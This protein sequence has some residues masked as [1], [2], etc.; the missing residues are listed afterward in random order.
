MKE[1]I[2]SELK[3]GAYWIGHFVTLLAT[4]VGVYYAAIAGFD[5]A[6]RLEMVKADRGTY[7]VADSL[8]KELSFNVNN[9]D[10]Y[11]DKAKKGALY[12][13]TLENINL[14]D[15]V[16]QASKFSDSTFEIEPKILSEVSIYYFTVGNAIKSFYASRMSTTPALIKTIKGQTAKLKQQKTLEHLDAYIKALKK[17]VEDRGVNLAQ[18]TFA[19]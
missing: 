18:P 8:Y 1:T 17:S 11:L 14:N 3:S 12:K 15:Y 4:V 13:K 5:V 7:Y 16:F 6:V 9:M 2:M 10:D 19:Q